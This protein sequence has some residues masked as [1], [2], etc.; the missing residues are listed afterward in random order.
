[1]PDDVQQKI[2]I[3]KGATSNYTITLR[4]ESDN[5]VI[6]EYG[7]GDTLASSVW[8]GDDQPTLF[9]PTVAWTTDGSDG[10]VSI[11]FPGSLTA[12]KDPGT[13]V[14]RVTLTSSGT[15]LEVARF[16]LSIKDAP[17]S[18]TTYKFYCN[19]NDLMTI[20]PWIEEF[21]TTEDLAS[22]AEQRQEARNWIDDQILAVSN[23]QFSLTKSQIKTYLDAD[24]LVVTSKIKRASAHY[25]IYLICRSQV[26]PNDKDSA[27]QRL[28]LK[29]KMHAISDLISATVEISTSEDSSFELD[30]GEIYL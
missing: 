4:K 24:G 9:T 15:T 1:M 10:K 6:T 3:V 11:S 29:H 19:R 17:G 5:S 26:G 7:V 20:A 14:C 25:A 30:C 28:S 16:W 22:F 12:D 23:Q 18:A 27:Y 13:Y 21:Q 8:A 2:Q